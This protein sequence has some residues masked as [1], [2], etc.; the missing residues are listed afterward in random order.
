MSDQ[1]GDFWDGYGGV[2]GANLSSAAP[3]LPPAL[4]MASP[5]VGLHPPSS[6]QNVV[7]PP[8][9]A[10]T[11]KE[12][13]PLQT[14]PG[15]PFTLLETPKTR[16]RRLDRQRVQAKRAKAT[17]NGQSV[18]TALAVAPVVTPAPAIT[19]CSNE[20]TEAVTKGKGK[21]PRQPDFS[22]NEFIRL[23]HVM[24]S[25]EG[26]DALDRLLT[27]MTRQQVN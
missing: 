24:V 13:I 4:S 8:P 7:T 27:G 25:E 15:L 1:E 3:P 14:A 5:E 16:K 12:P 10:S 22:A 9:P 18:S 21:K 19:H 2:D 26:K 11:P 6:L 23:W 17:M 20:T